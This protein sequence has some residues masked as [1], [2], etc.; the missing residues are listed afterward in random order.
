MYRLER[1]LKDHSPRLAIFRLVKL[2]SLPF[3]TSP[4]HAVFNHRLFRRR[5]PFSALVESAIRLE[6]ARKD[7]AIGKL[8][9]TTMVFDVQ[10]RLVNGYMMSHDRDGQA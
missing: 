7:D 1:L 6:D 3:P 9:I 5:K 2:Y 10:C 4:T 8:H